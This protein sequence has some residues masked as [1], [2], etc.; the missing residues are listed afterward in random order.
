M[1]VHA[2]VVTSEI[3]TIAVVDFTVNMVVEM[4]VV[5]SQR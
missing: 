4:A 1:E 2:K 3:I 5:D